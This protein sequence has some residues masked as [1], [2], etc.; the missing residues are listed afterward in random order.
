MGEWCLRA[1][2]IGSGG[3]R[4]RGRFATVLPGGYGVAAIGSHQF[5]CSPRDGVGVPDGPIAEGHARLT[6]AA[7]AIDILEGGERDEEKEAGLW[8]GRGLPSL[9]RRSMK[10]GST[11][12]KALPLRSSPRPAGL[13]AFEVVAL[14]PPPGPGMTNRILANTAS[15]SGAE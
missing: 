7:W 5:G 10:F 4:R 9:L 15:P 1:A 3:D 6:A 14:V 11:F 2:P 13:V 8:S 12:G